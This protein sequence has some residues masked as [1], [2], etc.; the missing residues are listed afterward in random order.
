MYFDDT[1]GSTLAIPA[2]LAGF[3]NGTGALASPVSFDYTI[4]YLTPGVYNRL[5]ATGAGKQFPELRH[6]E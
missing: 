6:A 4:S 2:N 5:C 1:G 3:Y